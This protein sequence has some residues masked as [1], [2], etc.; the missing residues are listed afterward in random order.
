MGYKTGLISTV[1]IKILH[2][3]IPAAQTTAQ[4]DAIRINEVRSQMVDEGCS[5]VFMEV[6]SHALDQNR[7]SGLSFDIGVY[8]NI[9]RDHMDYHPTIDHYIGSKKKLFDN[10]KNNAIAIINQD[11][12]F[13]LEMARDITARTFF[14]GL[15]EILI[16]RVKIVENRFHG[17]L[18]KLMDL[19]FASKLL[20]NLMHIIF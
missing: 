1:N 8:T 9:S 11:D 4:V 10:L 7:V 5:H 13:G 18:L 6:S 20:E 12:S 14:Y 19:K 2:K 15:Q 16:L 17:L 3:T